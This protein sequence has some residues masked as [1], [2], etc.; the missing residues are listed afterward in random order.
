[1]IT[2]KI[3]NR[4]IIR[5]PRLGFGESKITE[6]KGRHLENDVLEAEFVAPILTRLLDLKKKKKREIIRNPRFG[7][8]GSKIDTGK[9]RHLENN[10]LEDELTASI[11]THFLDFFYMIGL[12]YPPRDAP[13]CL[14]LT[15]IAKKL[16]ITIFH[17]N[18]NTFTTSNVPFGKKKFI[19]PLKT[20][21]HIFHV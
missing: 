13:G 3:I 5:N 15:K 10:V 9:G 7:F 14:F 1:M 21:K 16:Y 12:V 2:L 20:K 18:K 4:E 6:G 17:I 19:N 8:G 11:L